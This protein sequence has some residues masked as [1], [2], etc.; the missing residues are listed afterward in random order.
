M[1]AMGVLEIDSNSQIKQDVM[2]LGKYLQNPLFRI[3]VFAP[4]NY[5]KSTLLNAWLGDKLLPMDLIPT[6]GAAISVKY[7]EE[8]TTCITFKDGKKVESKGTEILKEYAVLDSDRASADSSVR[9]MRYDVSAVEVYYPDPWLKN[10]IELI[11]LP[12]TDDRD[13]LNKLVRD[14]LL[15]TDL[16]IQVLDARK[17]MTLNEREN[18]RDWLTDRDIKTVIFA[19]N[20]LNLIPLE[21][22]Q[23]VSRRMRFVAESFRSELPPNFSNLY[24]I[25]ALPAL[26]AKL[27][28]DAAALATTGLNQFVS[29]VEQIVAIQQAEKSARLPRLLKAI[30]PIKQALSDKIDAVTAELNDTKERHQSQVKVKQKAESILKQA[31]QRSVSEFESWLYLPNQISAYQSSLA[32]ALETGKLQEWETQE[33]QPKLSEHQTAI[34]HWVDKASEFFSKQPPAELLITLPQAPEISIPK[35]AETPEK[36]SDGTITQVAIASGIGWLF[37]GPVGAAIIGGATYLLDR[38]T[39]PSQQQVAL[40]PEILKKA[41]GEGAKSYLTAFSELAVKNLKEYQQLIEKWLDFQP[42]AEPKSIAATYHHLQLL[43]SLQQN[44]ERASNLQ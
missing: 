37:G 34:A 20:F 32:T 14:R 6:T 1:T 33:F 38:E 8:T 19:I 27:K 31:L 17:L 4:F 18:L 26:R 3:A 13:E 12:G 22:Q 11:D 25:D 24:R 39:Q 43:T 9:C 35:P 21:E 7:G 16:I 41:C 5:G 10:G 29:A 44:I 2:A 23:E 42:D 15:T 30:A 28:G 40:D 36:S